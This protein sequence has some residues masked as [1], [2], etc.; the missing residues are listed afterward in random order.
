MAAMNHE[1]DSELR[2]DAFRAGK[3]R[4]DLF[5]L[6]AGGNVVIRRFD[7]HDHVADASTDEVGIIPSLAKLP[8]DLDGS[9]RF[10]AGM[11]ASFN[12]RTDV[13]PPCKGGVAPRGVSPTGRSHFATTFR[14]LDHPV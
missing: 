7:L 2:A 4:H 5:R 6:R 8:N 13:S 9:V 11:I 12:G 10:H 1:D 14:R 3:N